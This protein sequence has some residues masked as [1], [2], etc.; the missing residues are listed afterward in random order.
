MEEV[1]IDMEWVLPDG[2]DPAIHTST[3]Y[4]IIV[5]PVGDR[6][7]VTVAEM[8]DATD[9]EENDY[10]LASRKRFRSK[11]MAIAYCRELAVKHGLVCDLARVGDDFLD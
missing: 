3:L 8:C 6:T 9:Y 10:S 7:K 1:M 2:Y 11:Q 5:Y 4:W